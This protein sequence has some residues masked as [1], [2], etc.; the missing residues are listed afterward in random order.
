MTRSRP[1][2]L[3]LNQLSVC[4]SLNKKSKYNGQSTIPSWESC[5]RKSLN[6]HWFS[7]F[8]STTSFPTAKPAVQAGPS[9]PRST[10]TAKSLTAGRP[11]SLVWLVDL[12]ALRLSHQFGPLNEFREIRITGSRALELGWQVTGVHG[13]G[14]N[15]TA[16]NG[17]E[18][19]SVASLASGPV[20]TWKLM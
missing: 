8:I 19:S 12:R 10:A 7:L 15:G 16:A 5:Y 9:L 11:D 4:S 18:G 1:S 2:I 14:K 20:L 17:G 13:F 3:D 6:L